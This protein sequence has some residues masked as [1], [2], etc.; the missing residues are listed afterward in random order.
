MSLERGSAS[1]A[2]HDQHLQVERTGD[3]PELTEED[4]RFQDCVDLVAG[5]EYITQ[6][7][8]Q[9]ILDSLGNERS[10][11]KFPP[12]KDEI[13]VPALWERDAKKLVLLQDEGRAYIFDQ[14]KNDNWWFRIPT[15]REIEQGKV[16]R[17]SGYNPETPGDYRA[18]TVLE[19]YEKKSR[20]A[21]A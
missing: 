6:E 9:Y 18:Q 20:E 5:A 2:A 13:R 10:W 16:S 11:R 7:M 14:H 4:R 3:Y 15:K 1:N 19:T 12:N 8:R 17:S 21:S